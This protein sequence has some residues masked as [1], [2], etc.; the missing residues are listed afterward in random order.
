M[1][2]NL[3]R[4]TVVTPSYNQ[5]AFLDA[6]IRSVLDQDYPN[7]E[8]I[9]MDGGSTDGSVAVIRGYESRLAHWTSARDG[10]QPHAINA[11]FRRATGD[12]LCWINSDDLLAPDALRTVAA[13]W[14]PSTSWMVGVCSTIDAGGNA[15][16]EF[17]P[18]SPS[19]IRD[20]IERLLD[21]RTFTV[22]QPSTFWS[23]DAW[24]AAGPLDESLHYSFDHAFFL[25]LFAQFGAPTA[26]G[27]TLARF[28]IHPESK[29][30][31]EHARF[32][33]EAVLAARASVGLLGAGAHSGLRLKAFHRLGL[34]H[35]EQA[36]MARERSRRDGVHGLMSATRL[37]PHLVIH[38]MYWRT[39][40]AV[41][42]R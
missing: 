23:R 25:R 4:I 31:T 1:M 24:T 3:P 42:A 5:A 21:G 10:G 32:K 12:I 33:I 20:W 35:L 30:S 22:P 2:Q 19:G 11:G 34:F 13:A 18:E 27:P 6:T 7:L 17:I 26:L 14:T 36:R 15:V 37:A 29:T 41:M 8:Y 40:R 16:G 38:P 39:V 28:R 9:V